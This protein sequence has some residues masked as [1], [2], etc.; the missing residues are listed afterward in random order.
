MEILG[1]LVHE[2]LVFLLD[3]GLYSFEIVWKIDQADQKL[4]VK[5]PR[6]LKPKP[7]ETLP[8]GSSLAQLTKKVEDPDASPT[9]SGRKRWKKVSLIVRVIRFQIP[10]FRP[11]TLITNILDTTITARELALHYHRR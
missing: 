5:A 6:T 2:G 4:I 3:A 10:G 8:D 7:I 11:V 1:R 9:K